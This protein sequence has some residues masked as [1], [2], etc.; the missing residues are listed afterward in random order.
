[1]HFKS[2]RDEVNAREMKADAQCFLT[3]ERNRSGA[4]TGLLTH[5]SIEILP[6]LFL[7]PN[8]NREA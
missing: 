5:F 4:S 8:S 7:D 1:M 2:R 3:P 6:F